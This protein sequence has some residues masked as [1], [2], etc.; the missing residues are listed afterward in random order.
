MQIGQQRRLYFAQIRFQS[1]A[2]DAK[3]LQ[4]AAE[5][6]DDLWMNFREID[7]QSCI[8]DEQKTNATR[9]ITTLLEQ[10]QSEYGK[11]FTQITFA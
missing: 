6:Q 4:R 9:I 5:S 8:N 10:E 3:A 2:D 11:P 1:N 7:S